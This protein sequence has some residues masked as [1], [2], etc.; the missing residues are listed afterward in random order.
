MYLVLNL[1]ADLRQVTRNLSLTRTNYLQ[2]V[3]M[4]L[5]ERH[6]V[7]TKINY[8]YIYS[9]LQSIRTHCLCLLQDL[10]HRVHP[11][12]DDWT[13]RIA[14]A[15]TS[16]THCNKASTQLATESPWQKHCI[17]I[18]CCFSKTWDNDST[19][20]FHIFLNMLHIHISVPYTDVFNTN[21]YIQ[22]FMC[23]FLITIILIITK[24]LPNM[25]SPA[26]FIC[27]IHCVCVSVVSWCS[28][29]CT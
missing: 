9:C 20:V 26:C 12:Q 21:T 10:L 24:Y 8:I 22:M 18:C 7:E 3:A 14:T 15:Y 2:T 27:S 16:Q 19:S 23:I 29:L 4:L 6:I 13:I 5:L 11:K 28:P 17:C 25:L 1:V